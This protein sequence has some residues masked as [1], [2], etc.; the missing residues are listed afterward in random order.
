SFR[1]RE[2]SLL[3]KE[4][5]NYE[6]NDSSFNNYLLSSLQSLRSFWAEFKEYAPLLHHFA[7]KLLVI[8]PYSASC[9]WLFLMLG[10]LRNK[11]KKAVPNIKNKFK[12]TVSE[13]LFYNDRSINIFF[14]E[15]I[16]ELEE[17]NEE[18]K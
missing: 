18:L 4:L 1:K 11:L 9:E 10:W 16:N 8:I 12:K 2:A 5:I 6:N 17:L 3:Y 15:N 7:M 14:K 13:P